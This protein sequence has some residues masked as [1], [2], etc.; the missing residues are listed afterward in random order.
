MSTNLMLAGTLVVV[1]F[2]C[3]ASAQPRVEADFNGDGFADLAVGVP[4][5]TVGNADTAG[6][7]NVIYGSRVGLSAAGNQIWTQG[8]DGVDSLQTRGVAEAGDAFGWAVAA[9]DFNGDGFD[10]LAVGVN[11]R[12][13]DKQGAGAVNVI[14]GSRTGLTVAGNQIWTQGAPGVASLQVQG[15][16]GDWEDFGD[17]LAVG[18]FNRDGQDDLAVGASGD[19]NF[20]PGSQS[21]QGVV[22]II[23]GSPAGLTLTDNQIWSQST[24]WILG[25]REHQDQFGYALATGDFNGDGYDDLAIGVPGERIGPGYDMGAVNVLYG[26]AVGL[27][28]GNNQI[29]TQDT[30]GIAGV[31]EDGDRFG[32]A[33]AAG[34]FDGDGLDD[35]AIGVPGESVG[36]LNEAGAVNILYGI[37]G[38]GLVSVNSQ[39]WTQASAGIEGIAEEGDGFGAALTVGDF[40][41]DGVDDLAVGVR[42]L[43]PAP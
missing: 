13:G 41:G 26:S 31:A 40:N 28:S 6:A 23:F 30:A 27:S 8:A 3:A 43:A 18:D 29:W 24:A 35:L 20:E 10:D 4:G 37:W 36:G 19:G 39:I 15:V 21:S 2:A 1:G 17:S 16:A 33:L 34:D 14:Y 32:E 42:S 9:G 5:E 12:V 25:V 11:E 38:F 7:V 22:H